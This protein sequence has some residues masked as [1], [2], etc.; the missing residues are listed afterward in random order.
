LASSSARLAGD[1]DGSFVDI[2]LKNLLPCVCFYLYSRRPAI[3]NLPQEVKLDRLSM[4][5]AGQE[6]DSFN[7][8]T[9][10]VSINPGVNTIKLS[11][12]VCGKYPR[13]EH[14]LIEHD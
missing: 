12:M 9:S 1:Q 3:D 14:S 10:N 4:E 7:Y 13:L 6:D 11:C 2:V 8:A 5:V